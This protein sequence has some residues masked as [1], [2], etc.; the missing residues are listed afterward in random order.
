MEK[1]MNGANPLPSE[2]TKQNRQR[3]AQRTRKIFYWFI[4]GIAAVGCLFVVSAL[5]KPHKTGVV[6]NVG[7]IRTYQTTT[8]R[9]RHRAKH[10]KYA[11]D[12]KV[13]VKD[14]AET[15]TV[16]YRVGN[17]DRIPAV[18]DEIEF[19]YS[20]AAGNTPY[21][22]MG[23]VWVGIAI[24]GADAAAFLAHLLAKR[25]RKRKSAAP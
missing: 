3:D 13:R 11:A 24:L 17:P 8:G 15:E 5:L 2:E 20:L 18:G 22:E 4:I 21:P 6:T 7:R 10:T 23:A 16:Y 9:G 1:N 19:G 14:S 25:R 12:V